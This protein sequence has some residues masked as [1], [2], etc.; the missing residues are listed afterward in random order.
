M[1]QQKRRPT[2]LLAGFV[3]P[4]HPFAV[5]KRYWELYDPSQLPMPTTSQLPPSAPRVPGKKGGEL[6]ADEP[7]PL[8]GKLDLQLT[9]RLIHGY[10]AAVSDVDAQIGKSPRRAG[11]LGCTGKYGR[12]SVGRQRISPW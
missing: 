12:S 1:R 3:R 9:R 4:Y 2:L 10:Y 11:T 5:S 7:I 6:A 8:D